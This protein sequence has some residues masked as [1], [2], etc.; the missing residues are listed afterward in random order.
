MQYL[1]RIRISWRKKNHQGK[2]GYLVIDL[3][4]TIINAFSLLHYTT[5][6]RFNLPFTIFENLE[7]KSERPTENWKSD[8]NFIRAISLVHDDSKSKSRTKK[9]L[10]AQG[11]RCQISYM[12]CLISFFFV[13]SLHLL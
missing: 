5:I 2:F 13:T 12:P 10:V 4:A 8:V 1:K 7:W 6:C 11:E 9:R 3:L